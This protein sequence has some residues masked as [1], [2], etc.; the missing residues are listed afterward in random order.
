MPNGFAHILFS[1]HWCIVYLGK[2]KQAE[3]ASISPVVSRVKSKK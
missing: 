1:K 2:D 3:R